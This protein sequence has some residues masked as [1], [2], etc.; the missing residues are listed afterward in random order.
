M[1]KNAPDFS[2]S[3]ELVH[4]QLAKTEQRLRRRKP[5]PEQDPE[6]TSA[7]NPAGQNQDPENHGSE[8]ASHTGADTNPGENCHDSSPTRIGSHREQRRNITLKVLESNEVKFSR[9]FH[10]LQLAGD[11]RRKQDLADEAFRLL[12]A[13]YKEYC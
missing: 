10:Q 4:D 7:A 1:S 3:F 8:L 5:K 6:T 9:L 11:P 13:V 2:G 12:F